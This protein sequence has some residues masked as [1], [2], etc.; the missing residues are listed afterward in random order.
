MTEARANGWVPVDN[1]LF[2][3]VLPHA[4]P[5]TFKIVAAV[6]RM[7][8]GWQQPPD[9]I[10]FDDFHQLTGIASRGTLCRAIDDALAEGFITRSPA[11]RSFNYGLKIIPSEPTIVPQTV[12]K[13]YSNR[14]QNRTEVSTETVPS[15]SGTIVEK[16]E[17]TIE[18]PTSSSP[19]ARPNKKQ[20]L[21]E[22]EAFFSEVS[23]LNLPPRETE[24]QRKAAAVR[25]W[26]PL[27][28]MLDLVDGELAT[29]QE[30]A[31]AV[32]GYQ[33]QRGLPVS[34][35]QSILNVYRDRV[36][37]RKVKTDR[38]PDFLPNVDVSHP[39]AETGWA[40]GTQR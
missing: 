15:H 25:W 5:T 34:A 10:T 27:R 16:Q 17:K 33:R 40:P 20:L 8:V 31:R 1:W 38:P 30:I 13:S 12:S 22:F 6:A 29:A 39:A 37:Q 11:G 35:P 7:T 2:D 26:H 36:A 9:E 21:G 18:E 24:G 32:V 19:P 28:E 3:Y 23:G 4:R 14:S